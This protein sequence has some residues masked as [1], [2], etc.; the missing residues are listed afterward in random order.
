MVVAVFRAGAE[1]LY[2]FEPQILVLKAVIV[3]L[4]GEDGA[5]KSVLLRIRDVGKLFPT[6]EVY[7]SFTLSPADAAPL[8]E[9]VAVMIRE[10]TVPESMIAFVPKFPINDHIYPVAAAF[11]EV[12]AGRIGAVYLYFFAPQMLVEI[13]VIVI[14][15]GLAGTLSEEFKVEKLAE[16]EKLLFPTVQM[17]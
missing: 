15:D 10:L 17:V 12:A 3:I 11:V 4:R 9:N 16:A 6:D 14:E 5:V 1:Y 7:N 8:F 2:L 13:A